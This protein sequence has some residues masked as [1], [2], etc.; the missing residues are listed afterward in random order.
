MSQVIQGRELRLLF[1]DTPPSV[2]NNAAM[3]QPPY[4]GY[5]QNPYIN[6]P[7]SGSIH[8]GRGPVYNG[9]GATP[10][11]PYPAVPYSRQPQGI[12]REEILMVSED[13]VVSLRLAGRQPML[14]PDLNGSRMSIPR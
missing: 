14:M 4:P 11:H 12:G 3:H 13:R 6:P 9:Y 1:A 2:T 7:S 8:G 5:E 10:H